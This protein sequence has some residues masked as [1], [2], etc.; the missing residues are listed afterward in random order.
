M[1][2]PKSANT[3][4]HPDRLKVLEAIEKWEPVTLGQLVTG[5]SWGRMQ[6]HL[7]IL[8][9]DGKIWKYVEGGVVYYQRRGWDLNPRPLAGTGSQV[10]RLGPL[11][12]PG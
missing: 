7:Y 11:G 6:W 3:Y 12:H 2:R 1:A 5:I 8:E 9:R 10:P 4:T